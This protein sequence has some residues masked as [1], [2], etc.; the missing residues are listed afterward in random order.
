MKL[1][2]IFTNGKHSA[3]AFQPTMKANG[4]IVMHRPR[5][6]DD[7]DDDG[8][9]TSPEM[10]YMSLVHQENIRLK[11]QLMTERDRFE[12]WRQAKQIVEY[13]LLQTN[14]EKQALERKLKLLAKGDTKRRS[15]LSTNQL[16]YEHKIQILLN[17]IESMEVEESK[18]FEKLN[19]KRS[20]CEEL[21]YKLNLKEQ[22]IKQ[23]T[24]ELHLAKQ[25]LQ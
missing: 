18:L 7:S 22:E 14:K 1:D 23:L 21:R 3:R 24:Y 4:A 2:H 13:E 20:E 15:L 9:D 10:E 6:E 19:F 5:D 17:E 25:P 12:S 16:Y 8:V 11:Q